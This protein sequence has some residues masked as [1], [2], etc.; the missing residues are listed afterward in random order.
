MGFGPSAHSCL[1]G[2]RYAYI[3]DLRGYISSVMQGNEPICE[4]K[5]I[6][7]KERAE[8]YL[9]LR[10]RTT[11]GL[12]AQEYQT[13]IDADFSAIEKALLEFQGQGWCCCEDNRWRFTP[14]GFL[15][16]TPIN[17]RLAGGAGGKHEIIQ[18]HHPKVTKRNHF[19]KITFVLC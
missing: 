7:T 8:E 15:L 6:E 17:R 3:S 13:N 11:L 12:S 10:M 14:E 19:Y 9:M 2:V 16:S 18:K 1:N 5:A 4:S